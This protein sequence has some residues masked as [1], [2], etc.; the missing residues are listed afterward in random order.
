MIGHGNQSRRMLPWLWLLS[1]CAPGSGCRV[2]CRQHRCFYGCRINVSGRLS[3]ISRPALLAMPS[4]SGN[5][6]VVLDVGANMDARPDQLLQYA[7]MGR[8]YA[9]QLLGYRNPRVA[10]L[11]VG[12]EPNKGNSQLKKTYPLF[13]EHVTGFCGNIEGDSFFFGAA[14]VV[15]CDGF[16]GNVLLKAAEGVA[17]GM[18]GDLKKGLSS[19]LRNRLGA[20]LL[21]PALLRIKDKVDDTEYGGAPLVGIKGVCIKCHGSSRAVTI[22]QALIKQVF[23]F[24]RNRVI[25]KFQDAAGGSDLTGGII[26]KGIIIRGRLLPGSASRS[27]G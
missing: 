15:V 25:G 17:R 3:G 23:P 6:V 14:E 19:S 4:F 21:M 5:P 22:E 1:C 16:V 11:N 24:V 27:S 2:K 12:S 10:L 13:T 7:F 26:M 8:I 20:A 9:Q 18:L